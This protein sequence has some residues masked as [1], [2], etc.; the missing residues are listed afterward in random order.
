MKK[1][2]VDILCCPTCKGDL[3][4]KIDKEEKGDILTGT[5]TCKTCN[6]TYDIKD[7]IPNLLPKK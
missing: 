4:L 1:D 3:I 6:V 7:G 5:F 2:L